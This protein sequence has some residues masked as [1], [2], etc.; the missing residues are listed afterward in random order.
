MNTLNNHPVAA[1]PPHAPE[2][3]AG[4]LGCILCASQ[5]AAAVRLLARLEEGL[6]Y[7]LRHR[8]AFNALRALQQAGQP[9]ET[10]SLYQWLKE[11]QS[12]DAAGG[13]AYVSALSAQ[14]PSALNF[15]Y[16]LGILREKSHRRTA[17]GFAG[18]LADLAQNEAVNVA[19]LV[20]D[21]RIHADRL[22]SLT[23]DRVWLQLYSPGDLLA[24]QPPENLCLIGDFH[25]TR[26]EVMVIGGAPGV[27][28]SRAAVA[29]AWSGATGDS[30]LGLR[31]HRRFKTMILQNENGLHRLHREF[32]QLTATSHPGVE[33]VSE[34]IRI[35]SPPP[36]GMAF[37]RPEF[38][39][40][41]RAAAEEF[42]PDVI[43]F[44]PWNSAAR[45]DRARDYLETFEQLR[46][47][48]P[49]G[50][51]TP[52]LVVV[53]HTR[54]PAVNERANGRSLLNTLAGSYVLASVPRCVFVMQAAS[55]EVEDDRVVWTCCKN[56]NGE[57]GARSAWHRREAGFTACPEFDWEQFDPAGETDVVSVT[58]EDMQTLFQGG[59]RHIARRQAVKELMERTRCCRA[60]AYQA[61]SGQGKFGPRL[62]ED[63]GLLRWRD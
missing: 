43:V 19:D 49:S 10:A 12:L 54:K 8:R 21:A 18:R 22:L 46:R 57:L 7:D 45:D 30:W 62:T 50:E 32:K 44:D 26:G 1:M 39:A 23:D 13:V 2:A 56:N 38:V 29:L 17:L 47:A 9:Q 52:A 5:P 42:V 63:A 16:F 59:R 6:F 60:V 61:C 53:A 28:K 51:N 31:V 33:N 35:C 15:D 20:A 34:Y 36:F 27:G 4:A 55:D 58:E 24:Y 25:A 41:V 3:E 48:L 14:T 11:R 40:A 37:N